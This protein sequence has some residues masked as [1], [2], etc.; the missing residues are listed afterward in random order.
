MPTEVYGAARQ[1][2][3]VGQI[4][5]SE[6]A[7]FVMG[8]TVSLGQQIGVQYSRPIK[9][10]PVMGSSELLQV[11][12]IG[13]GSIALGRLVGVGGLL[14]M[15]NNGVGDCGQISTLHLQLNGGRCVMAPSQTVNFGGGML[16][17]LAFQVAAGTPEISE[18]YNIR[19]TSLERPEGVV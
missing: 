18:N 13:A 2:N 16:E 5:S 8:T 17:G 14:E 11:P 4:R 12:G 6:F 15:L 7:R 1:I 9:P 19:I 10:I 3:P